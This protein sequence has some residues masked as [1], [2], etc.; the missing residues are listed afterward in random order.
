MMDPLDVATS[1]VGLLGSAG[2]VAAL[3]LAVRKGISEAPQMMD[4]MI[5]QVGEL[6]IS[7]SAVQ[8]F[9]LGISSASR[10]RIS[11]IRVEQ[12]VAILTEAVLTFSELEALV[13]SIV[14][15]KGRL[16]IMSRLLSLWKEDVVTS[17]MLRMERHKSSLSLMLNIAQCESDM[18]A[19]Q[20]R[21][22]LQSLVEQL[23]KSNHDI[24]LRF[25]SIEENL[26]T[27]SVLTYCYRNGSMPEVPEEEL[28]AESAS[29]QSDLDK[30][31]CKVCNPPDPDFT[32]DQIGFHVDLGAS[33]VYRRTEHYKSDVSFTSSAIRTHAWS[34]FSGLSLSEVSVI[35]AIALPLYLDEIYNSSW[36]TLGRVSNDT[37]KAM[38]HA[39]VP[40]DPSSIVSNSFFNAGA[41]FSVQE[42]I[43]QP[44]PKPV[45]QDAAAGPDKMELHKLVM[46]G[47]SGV[48][49]TKLVYWF[50]YRE[51][52][53]IYDP[54]I[55]DS[56]RKSCL[57]DG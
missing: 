21:E 20:S 8:S 25:Q 41:D 30:V 40:Q 50:I 57:I 26:E 51:L 14:Q 18:E 15:D 7:L 19:E 52:Y 31:H 9:L 47:D 23:L 38:S 32:D 39:T 5:S 11:M 45:D 42:N 43:P 48:G 49:K 10:G 24:S 27:R 55:E 36:Y 4:Q 53:D 33:R 22:T 34:V 29:Q 44:S 35:S 56:Y 37:F 54:T 12:L 13:T 28:Q 1:L 17:I 46:L 6:Q 16:P 2:K 3:L